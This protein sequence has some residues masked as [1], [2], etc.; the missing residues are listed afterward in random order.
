[1]AD[2]RFFQRAGPFAVSYI[3][4]L[5][6]AEPGPGVAPDFA[7]SDVAPLET[8]TA[9]DLSFLDNTKYLDALALSSAGVCIINPK[10]ADRAPQGMALLLSESPYKSYALAAQAFYPRAAGDGAISATAHIDP[11]AKI[12][13]GTSL[14]PG[15]CVGAGVEI[16]KNGQ[17]AANVVIDDGVIVGDDCVLGANVS[18]SHSIIGDRVRMYPGVRIGQDG[19][20]FAPDPH[21]HVKVPQLGRVIVHDDVEIGANS[22]I[23]RG[24]GPDTIIGAG[25]WIDNL[26]QVGHNVQLGRGCIMVAQSGIA[27][28]SRLGDFVVLGGQVAVSG[29]LN[30]G[31]GAQIAGQ[32][33]VV[34]DVEAGAVVGGTPAQPLRD[35][36]RQSILLAK[37]VKEKRGHK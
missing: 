23:D 13:G 22:C 15:V 26:V 3:V 32:S 14:G 11:S 33:G 34:A 8:A 2:T 10:Y 35:W 19:F 5:T 9:T 4:E 31:A 36:H 6:G 17:I 24:S 28:S 29:H 20:G 21:G 37:M 16:G 1:M 7:L 27:G 25:C 18:I 30:I 12:G